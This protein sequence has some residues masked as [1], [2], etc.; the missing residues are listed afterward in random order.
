LLLSIAATMAVAGQLDEARAE[1]FG[2]T[3]IGAREDNGMFANYKVV[4]KA[5]LSVPGSVTKLSLYAV[6][7]VK[8][9]AAQSLKAV[10]YADSGGSPGKLLATGTEV[11]YK[12]DVNG[13]GWLELPLASAVELNPGTYWIGFI[14][15]SET[16]GMGYKYDEV[17]NSRA[18]NTNTYSSGPTNPFGTA[19]KD[20]E[21]ASIYATYT[22]APVFGKTSVGASTDNGMFAN[23]KI[24][25][26]ATL[27]APGAVTKLTLYA[28]PGVNSPSAQSLKAVIYAD[29]EGSP[30]ELLGTGTEVTYKGNVNG[31]GW[32]ELPFASPVKLT[33]GT[34]WIGFIDGSES[35]GMGYAYDSVANSRAYNTNTYSSGP[36]NPF[37]TATKD[38]EQASLYATYTPAPENSSPPT[39]T[40]TPKPG[41]TL[42]E[43]HGSWT[44][45][46][47]SYA[48]QWLQCSALGE[49]CLAI[50]GATSQTYVPVAGDVGHTLKAQERATN[51]SGTSES[52]TSAATAEVTSATCTDTFT[53]IE[54]TW[55][56]GTNWSKGTPPTST[57]VACVGEGKTVKVS[58]GT[59]QTG[60]LEGEGAK[61]GKLEITGGSL[62]IAST[63]DSSQ[64]GGL[65]MTGGTLSGAASFALG[66]SF[67]W[68]GGT[69]SGTGKTVITKGVTSG[70]ISNTSLSERTLVNE[71]ATALPGQLLMGNGAQLQNTGTFKA[72]YEGPVGTADI[73][74]ASGSTS[75]PSIVNTGTFEKTESEAYGT[76]WTAVGVRFENQSVVKVT[77]AGSSLSF[78][79]GGSSTAASE[80]AGG[81]GKVSFFK[82]SFSLSGKW[83]G[84]V[85]LGNASVTL[86][87]LQAEGATVS[88]NNGGTLAVGSGTVKVSG[89]T[90]ENGTLTG[91]GT[92][93]A[94]SKFRWSGGSMSGAGKTVIEP[95]V[96]WN[97]GGGTKGLS[98]RS[99]VNEGTG[100]FSAGE[101]VMSNGARLENV[102]T[103]KANAEGP[104]GT[105]NIGIGK[106]S[107]SEPVIINTG[108]FEKT[109]SEA[110]G[111]GTTTVSPQFENY[112]FAGDVITYEGT[113]LIFEHPITPEGSSLYGG[114]ENPS[115][116]G[117][118]QATCGKPVSCATGNESFSQT[119]L[120]VG[121]RGV[122]L[123]LVRTYNSQAGAEGSKGVFGYGW[124]SSFSDHLSIE[125]TKA[126]LHQAHGATVAFTEIGG[127]YSA[128]AWSQDKLSGSKEAGYTL[129]Y[130]DQTQYKF[131]GTSG[132]L[133]NVTDRNGNATTLTYNEAGRL[134]T[135]ADPAGRKLTL[136]YNGEGLVESVEDAMKHVVKYAYESGNLASVNL[137]GEASARWS[138][139]YDGSHQL[140][141]LTDGRGGKT[142]NEYNSAHQVT[143][144]TDPLK[145]ELG[146]EYEAFRTKITNKATGAVTDE[147][148]TSGGEPD[149]ITRGAGTTLATTRSFSYNAGGYVASAT[150]ANK[151]T[152]TYGYDSEGNRTSMVDPNK[153]ETKWGYDAKHDVTS[154]TTPKGETTTIKRDSHGNAEAIERPAPESKTQTT[155]YKYGAH[156]ELES[157]EDPLK[158]VWKY[159]YDG[160][161]NRKSEIDPENDK[162]TWE[163]NKDG[164]QIATVSPRGN[165]EGVEAAKFTTKVEHDEQNRPIKV[166]DPL[167]HT[168]KYAYDGDG[169]LE[170][171]TDARSHTTAY[172]YNADNQPTKVK[173]PS[174]AT[175]ETEYDGE[176]HVIA[177]IDA[178]KHKTTYKRNIL[179]QVKEV[180]D[181]LK[182]VTTKEYDLAGNLEK[183]TDPAKRTATYK[184]DAANRLSEVS[185]S[186]GKTHAVTYE[187]DADG[188]RTKMED[189]T[190]TSKYAY[191][192][193]DRLSESE[194]G[195]KDLVKYE[196]DLANQQTKLT[197]PNTKAVTREYDNAGRLKSVLD[198][199]AN[200]TKFAYDRDS[201]LKTITDPSNE[202]AN[203]YNEADQLTKTVIKKGSEEL[204]SLTYARD[205]D[206]QLES[207]TQKG[208]PGEETTANTY[209]EN[210][211]L[212]KSGTAAYEYDSAD[213]PTKVGANTQSF[214]EGDELEKGSGVT[215]Y[216]FDELGERT[217]RT[218][219]SGPATTYG[220]DQAGNLTSVERPKEG[221][222]S[223]I[224]DSY[225]YDGD[226]LRASE[227]IGSTT[228]YV[229][230]DR[231]QSLSLLL[232]DGA[233]SYIYGSGGLPIE[234]VSSSGAVT[235]LHHDQQG[236][237]RLLTASSGAKEASFSYDAYGE[238]AGHTGTTTTPLGYDGQYANS[239]TGLIYMRHRVYDPATAQ[240]LSVDPIESLTGEPYSYTKDNPVNDDDPEGLIFGIQ[241]T[242]SFAEIGGAAEKLVGSVE[243]AGEEFVSK[244][245]G[246][247]AEAAAGAACLSG[248]LSP[249]GCL[250][251]TALG[252]T[253]ATFQTFTSPCPSIAG[254]LIDLIGTAPG[255]QVTVATRLGFAADA[256][257][258]AKVLSGVAGGSA[259]VGGPDI[260]NA[261]RSECGC[262]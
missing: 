65:T 132:R 126:T 101:L 204:A 24:A 73:G 223:E 147:S 38:S 161:G 171:V 156:G 183:L 237:T 90:M 179:G 18:Y 218:P 103:F 5:T 135:V 12:G 176:G 164:V 225:G 130:P 61:E 205:P 14:D 63:S 180:E 78:E 121:G 42:T 202:D 214:N 15:G 203:T 178:N 227:T 93:I 16:E 250:A 77:V 245:Y 23:Y 182:H 234:Q 138:F 259:I 29:S 129:T 181:P 31:S 33:T 116:L 92:M 255:V 252:F 113:R 21:Q 62:E 117:R 244:H 220:Y 80:A 184:Y 228:N 40:G 253:A 36:T 56:T 4:H 3:T 100:T 190:G 10:I 32:L 25:H 8:S 76:H 249:E 148:I 222:T 196:Y 82:G 251:L 86:E 55:Q 213:N 254:V 74:I 150:D 141:E 177:Q 7:G 210:N 57:D 217:K 17:A 96:S 224:K 85:F 53:A 194:D 238:Q 175:T 83:S 157:V 133:E 59:N 50:A 215:S 69:M 158:R 54:G 240:F 41:H 152:T 199:A 118:Q 67:K 262:Q 163:Y 142:L 105:K 127:S 51:S 167:G 209:D 44:G 46:P 216:T 189:A 192:Q 43:H 2:K 207:T 104:P 107:T 49:S 128:P 195:H 187:Y 75:A 137:P 28:V 122:G 123:D 188:N 111:T 153:N 201:N 45:E 212:T 261:A 154:V 47:T 70:E 185:Y 186:D 226:G 256:S 52:A 140:T 79:D 211:R 81:E 231:S 143:K 9:P 230:W 233:N 191:D 160:E 124:S 247:I 134:T 84:E 149:S 97:L 146:F 208:L 144:Q 66:T 119:D 58:A 64:L 26:K 99:F 102:G 151:H 258:A 13:S 236:S 95:G 88:L 242:P 110:Y 11:T 172:T 248:V 39:I 155:K 136:T 219:T 112:G 98:E 114:A 109:E 229:A 243:N 30:G 174:G 27:S 108:K 60:V 72:N 34:Y 139:K 91:A 241:G 169:N 120:T 168:T 198:W 257:V 162:R 166:T 48:Y 193:L 35:E 6:P 235:Y 89:L 131:S 145:R 170:T 159:E 232:N 165:E 200:T 106:E 87:A 20:S 68:T 206:G 239:D 94:S 260:V 173:Q 221:E 197:Y 71:G 115:A 37:G 19:S 1:T 125:T 22:P 246:Q